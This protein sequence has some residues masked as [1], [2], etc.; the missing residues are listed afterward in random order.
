MASIAAVAVATALALA[1]AV[2]AWAQAPPGPSEA[3]TPAPPSAGACTPG[4]IVDFCRDLPIEAHGYLLDKGA[5]DVPG[6]AATTAFDINDRGQ[7]VGASF[8]R[9][10]NGQ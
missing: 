5:I 4:G 7:I 1:S 2:P 8:R 6:F 3:G 9:P 10:G